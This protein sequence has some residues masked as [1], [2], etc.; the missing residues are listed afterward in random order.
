MPRFKMRFKKFLAL[1]IVLP[2]LACFS[3]CTGINASDESTMP[4]TQTHSPA[5]STEPT[6]GAAESGEPASVASESESFNSVENLE[7]VVSNLR[8]LHQ[9]FTSDPSAGSSATAPANADAKYEFVKAQPY[10]GKLYYGIMKDGLPEGYGCLIS[11]SGDYCYFGGFKAG[12]F[13]SAIHDAKINAVLLLPSGERYSGDFENGYR[14]NGYIFDKD[15]R[16]FKVTYVEEQQTSKVEMFAIGSDGTKFPKNIDRYKEVVYDS[17]GGG[18]FH[19]HPG[20]LNEKS[21]DND[22]WN[23]LYVAEYQNGDCLIGYIKGGLPNNF[24]TYYTKATGDFFCGMYNSENTGQKEAP[25]IIKQSGVVTDYRGRE[26]SSGN[27]NPPAQSSA[28]SG[29][30]GH[31]EVDRTPCVF[32][33]S[34]GRVDCITCD[35]TGSETYYGY[36]MG[37]QTEMKR[38]CPV[39]ECVYGK[40][41]CYHAGC[42]NGYIETPRYVLEP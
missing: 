3:S 34:S 20:T 10:D 12:K 15:N 29:G 8:E 38:P 40:I 17:N 16:E 32:C 11:K 26:A 36:S 31:W 24:G 35:G 21:I 33:K 25:S 6:S 19:L 41:P 7:E 37:K 9:S 39:V 18:S 13:D 27:E 5:P 30:K 14:T 23:R 2:V 42:T 28:S 4:D 1:F 22:E